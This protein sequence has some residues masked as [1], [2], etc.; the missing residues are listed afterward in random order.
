LSTRDEN[1]AARQFFPRL[2][3]GVYALCD[4]VFRDD[5]SLEEKAQGL[6]EGGVLVL[7]LRLK[8]QNGQKAL[9]SARAV[10]KMC[11]AH[12]A[13][14]LVNDRPDLALMS[15]AHGV[16]LGEDD[17]PPADAR[18]ILGEKPLIGVTVR[19]LA[20]AKAARAE[21]ADYVGL[22]PIFATRTKRLVA[23]ALGLDG[24]RQIAA[25]SPLPVVAIAGIGL[26]NIAQVAAAGAHGAAVLS[27]ALSAVDIAGRTRLL[28]EAFETG[29][30]SHNVENR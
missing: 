17:L 4:D 29:R 19:D 21:G 2:P 3:G 8:R 6:L 9:K 11:E 20:M 18:R 1:R 30:E 7:Q 25:A 10:V 27:E 23:P 5:L 26:E 22:G 12:G 28:R 13:V 14:C 16:H 15:G 24:L